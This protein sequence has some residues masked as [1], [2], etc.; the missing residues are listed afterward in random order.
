MIFLLYGK[1]SYL[2]SKKKQEI[3]SRF[4]D[5]GVLDIQTFDFSTEKWDDFLDYFKSQTIFSSKRLIFLENTSK[6]KTKRDIESFLKANFGKIVDNK[7][8]FLVFV[9]EEE[10]N[11][12]ISS[13]CL[14]KHL[15]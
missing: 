15:A 8:T 5:D 14:L 3:G 1:N 6:I 9:E 7:L 10:K 13:L 11:W 4:K 12:L 2:L